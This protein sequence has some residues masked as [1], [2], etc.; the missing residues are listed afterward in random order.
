[1]ADRHRAVTTHGTPVC[2][3][4][5]G[6]TRDQSWCGAHSECCDNMAP[7]EDLRTDFGNGDM[8]GNGKRVP[9]KFGAR[10]VPLLPQ[11]SSGSSY[12]LEVP[13]SGNTP[14]KDVN[15]F[16]SAQDMIVFEN[17]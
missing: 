6:G 9:V 7:A 4:D 13:G 11:V 10:N 1:M 16:P 17:K 12:E 2:L 8:L 15:M 14:I 3:C 5:G